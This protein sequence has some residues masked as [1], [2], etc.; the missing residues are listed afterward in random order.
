V[1]TT[2]TVGTVT[3]NRRKSEAFIKLVPA[4]VSMTFTK[5]RRATTDSG[6]RRPRTADSNAGWRSLTESRLSV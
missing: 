2:V 4:A 5:G 1:T 3:E 6:V